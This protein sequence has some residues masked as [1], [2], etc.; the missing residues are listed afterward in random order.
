MLFSKKSIAS[1]FVPLLFESM[2]S[3]TVGMI[4]SVM[5][6]SVG[7]TAVSGVSLVD[8]FNLLLV[9]LFNA[10]AIGG[11]VVVSQLIGKG[12][13]KEANEASKQL[14]WSVTIIATLISVIVAFLRLPLLNLV[15][16]Q[17]E[18]E[19][20]SHAQIYFLITSLSFPFLAIRNASASIFRAGGDSKYSLKVSLLVNAL[21]I[22]GNAL[23]IYVAK[24]GAAGAALS[25]LFARIVGAVISIFALGDNRRL[26]Y[27]EKL[28]KF[29]LNFAYIKNIFGI[30]I[31]NGLEN[32][33]FQFGK[34]LTQS[35]I[36]TLGTI[37]IA[38]NAVSGTLTSMQY[39]PGTAIGS[40]M[41]IVIGRCV[42]AGEKE[43]AKYYAKKLLGV[44]YVCIAVVSL[45][46][47]IFAPQL[48]SLYNL[49]PESSEVAVSII[50]IHSV[51]VS[52]IWPIAFPLSSCFRA[53]S[54]VKFTMVI[55]I[56][57]MWIFRVGLSY[58]FVLLLNCG[59]MGVWYAMFCDWFFRFVIFGIRF[60]KGT[61]LNKYKP[62]KMEKLDEKTVESS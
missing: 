47:G 48:V 29:K 25:T 38:A 60:I 62:L 59:V 9:Y 16:G 15:F 20:M 58:V 10:I 4:D 42:G 52:T 35:L 14:M 22:C 19:V 46:M 11:A 43:Q 41:L 31:P 17:V 54:D 36:S 33:M 61:W 44:A 51:I 45:L 27:V 6:S 18:P 1:I 26:V 55:A 39:I 57:S 12:D 21:N 56:A 28:F 2:L 34:V 3:V 30:G 8:T 5:V 23:L 49:S 13:L 32:G 40:T 7:E 24:L 53:A 50:R 37:S